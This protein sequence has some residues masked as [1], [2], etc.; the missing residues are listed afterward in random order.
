MEVGNILATGKLVQQNLPEAKKIFSM[1]AEK[2]VPQSKEALD[3]VTNL[4]TQQAK[5]PA[6]APKKS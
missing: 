5:A 3:A 6:T 1:L 4:M 2:N